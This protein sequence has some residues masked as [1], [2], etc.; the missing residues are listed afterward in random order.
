MR[1]LSDVKLQLQRDAS[2]LTSQQQLLSER[3]RAIKVRI[4][5]PAVRVSKPTSA[6][7][8]ERC[9]DGVEDQ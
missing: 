5:L 7:L 6:K 4:L 8:I 2:E 1:K 9:S 3:H